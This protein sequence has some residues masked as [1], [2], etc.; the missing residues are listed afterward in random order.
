MYRGMLVVNSKHSF[1]YVFSSILYVLIKE[2]ENMS[3]NTWL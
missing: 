1:S 2:K 3:N